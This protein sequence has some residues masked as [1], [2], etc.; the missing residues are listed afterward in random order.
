VHTGKKSNIVKL[1]FKRCEFV[2]KVQY[3]E[4]II[5]LLKIDKCES[6]IKINIKN[7]YENKTDIKSIENRAINA[8]VKTNI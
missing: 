8:E 1:V 6:K 4:S 3:Q 7:K 5:L 2:T